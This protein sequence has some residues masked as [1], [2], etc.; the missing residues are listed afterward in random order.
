MWH[1]GIRSWSTLGQHRQS[2]DL[3][4][5]QI[6]HFAMEY[7]DDP[8]TMSIKPCPDSAHTLCFRTFH[9]QRPPL[10]SIAIRFRAPQSLPSNIFSE[11]L[12]FLATQSLPSN[13]VSKQL[14]FH[15]NFASGRIYNVSEHRNNLGSDQWFI[16][17]TSL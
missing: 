7:I 9:R 14:R 6:L 4:T 2:P 1:E 16:N 17:F 5:R 11:Q 15:S 3:I 10:P 12:R 13:I 8:P